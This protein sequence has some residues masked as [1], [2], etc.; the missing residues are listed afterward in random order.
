MPI[1]ATRSG[2]QQSAD[3]SLILNFNHSG[4]KTNGEAGLPADGTSTCSQLRFVITKADAWEKYAFFCRATDHSLLSP[5]KVWPLKKI[6]MHVDPTKKLEVMIIRGCNNI[7]QHTPLLGKHPF[8]LCKLLFH[9][10]FP[11]NCSFSFGNSQWE[12]GQAN[13]VDQLLQLLQRQTRD[14]VDTFTQKALYLIH[15]ELS[16]KR[17]WTAHFLYQLFGFKLLKNSF[18]KPDNNF[19]GCRIILNQF[20]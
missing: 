8:N 2:D 11:R 17:F 19:R 1:S 16:S 7:F 6:N 13:T 9:D 3:G 10:L 18:R 4:R 15:I 5:L 12:L 14:W 20:Q